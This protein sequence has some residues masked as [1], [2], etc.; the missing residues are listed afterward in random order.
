MTILE[1]NC[2][3]IITDSGGVQPEACY[4]DKKC[5]VMRSET[6][7]LQALESNN[8]I[9]Y[10]YITPLDMFIMNFL[11]VEPIKKKGVNNASEKILNYIL[12]F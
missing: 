4:L 10:D 3:F 11:K 8:N 7:W 2:K 6:E 9:L 12:C 1:R 5:I